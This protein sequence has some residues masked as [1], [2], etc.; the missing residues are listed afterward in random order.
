MKIAIISDIHSNLEALTTA[1]KIIKNNN[2]KA[3]YSCGDI[4]GYGPDPEDCVDLFIKEAIIS[5]KGNHDA[6]VS[7]DD[8]LFGF[9]SYARLAIA[10]T[11]RVI[12]YE[13][14]CFLKD[15]PCQV[16]KNDFT[17]FHGSLLFT[18]PFKYILTDNDVLESFLKLKTPIGF[19]GHTHVPCLCEFDQLNTLHILNL[20]P[21]K[22]IYLKKESRYLINVGSVGQ[23]R[24]G[25]PRSAFVI[26]TIASI[27]L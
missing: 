18:N 24:D 1:L 7:G 9:N 11:K 14:E 2:V 20:L 8:I 12:S 15:L 19:Y 6:G 25:D 3:I 23:P 22:K 26:L 4:V 5:V 21:N 16:V 17:V 27:R 13:S 10:Y